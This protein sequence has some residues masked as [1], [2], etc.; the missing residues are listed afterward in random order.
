[1]AP[2]TDK[3]KVSREKLAYI[4][5]STAAPICVLIPISTWAV[6]IASLLEQAGAAPEGEGVRY[7]IQTIPYNVYGWVAALIVPLVILGVIP[8]FG[9]MKKAEKRASET[10]VLAPPGS[11]K[12][13]IHSGEKVKA[14]KNPRVF[15]F[16]LPI[17]VLI[18]STIYF[19]ID[20]QLGVLS[21]VAFLF[22]L[23]IP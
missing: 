17:M 5:D 4:V 14:P 10:G 1:M 22:I 6:Y 18:G 16:F 12:I 23:Y 19:D 8:I 7:F 15:N 2:I 11:E 3:Y 9:P 13:D 21:T 20:M